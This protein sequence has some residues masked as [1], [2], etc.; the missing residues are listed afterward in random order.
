[1]S[2][3]CQTLTIDPFDSGESSISFKRQKQEYKTII[4]AS[5]TVITKRCRYKYARKIQRQIQDTVESFAGMG[6]C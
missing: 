3:R 2:L 6:L 4:F 1:M 5:K